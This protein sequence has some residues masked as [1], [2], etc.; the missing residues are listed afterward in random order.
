VIALW[1]AAVPLIG[2]G[3]LGFA[4]FRGRA[5]LAVLLAATGVEAA[6]AA[7]LAWQHVPGETAYALGHYL[8]LDASS[9]LFLALI[10]VVFL[11]VAIYVRHRLAVGLLP[12][13]FEGFV[14]RSL[15]FFASCVLAVLS[16]HL[17]AMWV[18]LELGTFAIAPLIFYARGA[19]ALQASWKYLL[20]SVIG[21]G[22]NLV[23]LLCLARAIGGAHGHH[24]VTFFI[25]DLQ[26]LATLGDPKWWKL[27][28]ALMVFGLGTKLG[29]APMY[30]WLPDAYDESPA[31]VTTMLSAVQ[32]N[33]VLLA[34]FREISLF[35]SFDADLIIDELL[36]MGTLS[37]AVATLHIVKATNYKRLIAYASINHAGTIA[38][39]LSMG[40]AAGYGVVIYVVSNAVVKAMLFMTS[41]N[42]NAH[43]GTKQMSALRGVIRTMPFNG[44]VFMLGA[45]ALLGFAPFGSFLGEMIMLSNMVER[46]YLPVFFFTG[47]ALTIILVASG[48]SLFPMIWG[49]SPD[50]PARVP[51]SFGSIAANVFYVAV[52]LSL[53]VYT[54]A[55]LAA[56]F[57]EVGATLGG[58]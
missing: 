55:P 14:A 12:G 47:F 27:G 11:G 22:L 5:A 52:L 41:G 54:P 31:S 38:L 33:C 40:K 50:A 29:L 9:I 46:T 15:I 18:F 17:L 8:V 42:L 34:L 57:R 53:G 23:G 48:R 3:L 51:D 58:R 25:D 16:N 49:D 36:V 13:A 6:L 35:R 30:A 45:F 1:C 37:I 39:G 32:F 56:L 4:P 26:H 24:E 28:L 2:L 44:W 20:F 10:S 19:T 21:L 7:G 43:Y